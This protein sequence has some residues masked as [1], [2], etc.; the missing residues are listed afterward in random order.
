M[1]NRVLYALRRVI[2]RTGSGACH[3]K[4][5][6]E[7]F[8]DLR[9]LTRHA[10][11]H[12]DGSRHLRWCHGPHEHHHQL[13]HAGRWIPNDRSAELR[14]EGV[15]LL[16]C[17]GEP[18]VGPQIRGRRQARRVPAPPEAARLLSRWNSTRTVCSRCN[19][20]VFNGRNLRIGCQD[21][22]RTC[23]TQLEVVAGFTPEM[24]DDAG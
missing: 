12:R 17:R 6:G 4:C 2:K 8:L 15:Q 23:A 13:R 20:E 7:R 14:D 21:V 24:D 18:F 5:H 1:H 10:A 3:D 9:D 11:R 19:E 16:G 22:C